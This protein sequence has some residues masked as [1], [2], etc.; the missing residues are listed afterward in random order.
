M[1]ILDPKPLTVAAAAA[2]LDKAEAATTYVR[3]VDANGNPLTGKHVTIKVDSTTGEIL[4]IVAE[5]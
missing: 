3:F 5:A 1:G 2:K 4:D